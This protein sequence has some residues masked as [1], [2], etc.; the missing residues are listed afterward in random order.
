MKLYIDT[1]IFGGYFEQEFQ[2]W[3]RKLVE[4]ILDDEHT[5]IVSD[6][7]PPKADQPTTENLNFLNY[8]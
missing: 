4:E 7:I 5:A 3:N 1:S 8:G 6:I 2:L